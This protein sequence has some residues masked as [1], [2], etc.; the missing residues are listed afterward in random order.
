ML[1]ERQAPALQAHVDSELHL[2]D[3]FKLGGPQREGG[4][5]CQPC[6]G[7][8]GAP[9]S[10]DSLLGSDESDKSSSDLLASLCQI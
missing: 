7:A 5:S 4:E 10:V 1:L 9:S 2:V 8:D 6:G 3:Y